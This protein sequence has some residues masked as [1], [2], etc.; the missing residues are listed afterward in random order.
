MS[1]RLNR[2]IMAFVLGFSLMGMVVSCDMVM[3]P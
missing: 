2:Y 3:R 1:D